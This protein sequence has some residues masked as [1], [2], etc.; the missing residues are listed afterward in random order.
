MT[1]RLLIAGHGFL[2]KAVDTVFDAQGWRV[3]RLNRSGSQ[4]AAACDLSSAEST[5]AITGEY[6]TVIHCAASGGGGIE[7]YRDVYLEGCR[8][9]LAR[10]PDARVIFT[11]STSVYAQADHSLVT[12][13]SPAEPDS[14]R[15]R[16]LREAE[17]LVLAAR[18]V[19]A[20]LT[21]LYGPGRCH[22]L[23]NFLA[24]TAVLDG[25]GERIMNFIHRDDAAS[26]LHL[27]AAR[28]DAAGKVFNINGGY[29]SQRGVYQALADHFDLPIPPEADPDIP[30]KRGNTSKKVSS[31]RLSAL[32]WRP[33][34]NDFLSL[35]LACDIDA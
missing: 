28:E 11:S 17:D 3:T 26:A 2:G 31:A 1:K 18:G 13:D 25:A 21:G 29:A 10:F 20:R 4:G 15:A 33:Q 22:V 14:P 30:R 32:G 34:Y 19:V 5:A 6:D 16:L 27:L 8:N 7:S 12:E 35:A 9:L 24:A 23:K